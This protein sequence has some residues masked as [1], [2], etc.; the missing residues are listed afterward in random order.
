M[1]KSRRKTLCLPNH[2]PN[3]YKESVLRELHDNRE[4]EHL[5]LSTGVNQTLA[6][7]RDRFYWINFKKDVEE[8]CKRCGQCSL[9]KESSIIHE[10]ERDKLKLNSDR[11]KMR[12]DHRPAVGN[13]EEIEPKTTTLGR[14]IQDNEEN[15]RSSLPNSTFSKI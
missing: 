15:K 1:G 8:W 5:E 2:I 14:T 13:P 4:G 9:K 12:L 6:R 10:L 7:I 3:S 11:M